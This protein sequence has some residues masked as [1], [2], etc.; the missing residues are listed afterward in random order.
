MKYLNSVLNKK[1]L[2]QETYWKDFIEKNKNNVLFEHLPQ[3]D[4]YFREFYNNSK[5]VAVLKVD[6]SEEASKKCSY[7]YFSV[8][9]RLDDSFNLSPVFITDNSFVKNWTKKEIEDSFN[10][11][12]F[13]KNNLIKNDSLFLFDQEHS[14]FFKYDKG[15]WLEN[16]KYEAIKSDMIDYI[17]SNPIVML[18][19]GGDD[20]HLGIRLKSIEDANKLLDSYPILN[21]IIDKK[22][23]IG[24]KEFLDLIKIKKETSSSIEDLLEDQL[25][26]MN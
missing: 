26:A 25:F 6:I 17:I 16:K 14:F 13:D 2:E 18:F 12:R 24:E 22:E 3:L 20:G 1:R 21:E 11:N 19:K 4:M 10:L 15:N 9:N 7:R 23:F 8:K 5:L